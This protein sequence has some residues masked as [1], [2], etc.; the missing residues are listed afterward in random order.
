[1]KYA[2][3]PK[4]DKQIGSLRHYTRRRSIFEPHDSFAKSDD[5]RIR[6]MVDQLPELGRKRV[7]EF[8]PFGPY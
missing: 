4:T 6:L 8:V 5:P 7:P 3:T 1:M 2:P